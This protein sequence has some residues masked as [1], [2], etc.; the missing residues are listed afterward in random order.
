MTRLL[1]VIGTLL[2]VLTA[3]I[4][5]Q[6]TTVTA[7]K[8]SMGGVPI[9]SGTVTFTPVNTLGVAIPFVQGGG[10]L[11]APS[12]FTCTITDGAISGTCQIPDAELTTPAN[13]IYSIQITNT[14]NSKAFTLQAVTDITGASWALDAFA[15]AAITSSTEAVQ[16]SYGTAAAPSSCAVP[17]FYVRNANGGELFTCVN[18][19]EVQVSSTGS[20]TGTVTASLGALAAGAMVIGNGGS[21]T[22]VDPNITSDGNGDLTLNS[23]TV[24][25]VTVNSTNAGLDR[26]Q[27]GLAPTGANGPTSGY[28]VCYSDSTLLGRECSFNGDSFSKL[29]RQSDLTPA[30]LRSILG[31]VS[32]VQITLTNS[33]VPAN[34]CETGGAHV[35]AVSGLKATAALAP[36]ATSDVSTIVGFSPNSSGLW[37]DYWISTAGQ[38][39]YQLCNG[40]ALA[41]TPSSALVVNMGVIQ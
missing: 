14:A 40:T 27:E 3:P 24:N 16:V 37:L 9:A 25:Q 36:T 7:S 28:D 20:S 33:S 23:I 26:V 19:A 8:I 17:S 1:K 38:F 32:P 22:K 2:C 29:T 11:N 15:P 21:D 41:I 35:Q 5:A 4:Y 18:G 10:G 39:N 31:F 6:M 30:N 13:L 12:A 34:A